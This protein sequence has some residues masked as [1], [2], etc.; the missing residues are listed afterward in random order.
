MQKD[1]RPKSNV[2][3]DLV[4][5]YTS[6]DLTES[7]DRLLAISGIATAIGIGRSDAYLGGLW[8]GDLLLESLWEVISPLQPRPREYRAPSWSWGSV[9]GTIECFANA[10]VDPDLRLLSYEVA[11]AQPTARYGVLK[12]GLIEILGRMKRAYWIE[13]RHT[14]VDVEAGDAVDADFLANTREDSHEDVNTASMLVWC[15]QICPY[16]PKV[17]LDLSWLQTMK[18]P[19]DVLACSFS[20]NLFTKARSLA[21]L[22]SIER[23]GRSGLKCATGEKLLSGRIAKESKNFAGYEEILTIESALI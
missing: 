15:L 7:K 12:A 3:R 23:D 18:G 6:R 22:S 17:L 20:T 4:K 19:L 10:E 5:E 16:D 2:W 21:S 9:D 1:K 11:L 8:L 13:N 14:L